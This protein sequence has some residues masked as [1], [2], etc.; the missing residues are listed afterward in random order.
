MEGKDFYFKFFYEADGEDEDFVVVTPKKL[1]DEEGKYCDQSTADDYL[2]EEFDRLA[3][4][5]Y[6]FS[7]SPEKARQ[8]LLDNGFIENP[9][10]PTY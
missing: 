10:F 8:I 1:W 6:E 9:D 7:V 4:S 3:E 2:P 5:V